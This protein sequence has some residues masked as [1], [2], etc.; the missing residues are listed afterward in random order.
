MSMVSALAL[1]SSRKNWHHV[2]AP[3]DCHFCPTYGPTADH[4]EVSPDSKP[5]MVTASLAWERHSSQRFT[6]TV[7]QSLP[8][9]PLDQ[10]GY[11]W[12]E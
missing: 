1:T 12:D 11:Q 2:G 5:S 7:P 8:E 9:W 10:Q 4:A 6:E 3:L